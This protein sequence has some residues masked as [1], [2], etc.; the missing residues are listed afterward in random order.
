MRKVGVVLLNDVPFSPY[1]TAPGVFSD[2]SSAGVESVI[3][4]AAEEDFFNSE[5]DNAVG[6]SVEQSNKVPV[7]G[8]WKNLKSITAALKNIICGGW[9]LT[10]VLSQ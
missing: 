8:G 6:S 9:N 4:L 5:I 10:I 7:P 2:A 1:K 3:L